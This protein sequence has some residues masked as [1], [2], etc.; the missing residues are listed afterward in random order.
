MSD[1]PLRWRRVRSEPGPDYRIFR[2]RLDWAVSPRTGVEG[3]YVVLE[4]PDWVNVVAITADGQVVL[5]RQYRHGI[6][7]VE[8]EIPAGLVEPGEEPLAAAQRELAEETGYTGGRW[9]LLGRTRPNPAIQDNWCYNVLAEDVRLTAT[10]RLDPG[11][12]ITVEL[13][14]LAETRQLIAAGVINH[15]LMLNA[16]FWL[17]QRGR[18]A[19]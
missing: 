9:T 10:P 19:E 13:R 8:L 18:D 17:D 11:E 14:S 5:V 15:A 1:D 16:F 3:R 12:A 4:C 6:D 7:A 2:I